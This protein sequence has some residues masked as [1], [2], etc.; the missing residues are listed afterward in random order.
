MHILIRA[1]AILV[2]IAALLAPSVL[3]A[4]GVPCGPSERV[5]AFLLHQGEQ[6][7]AT[8][9]AGHGARMALHV[10]E[11]GRW[12]LLL[13]LPDGRSCILANGADFTLL[14]PDPAA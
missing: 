10:A 2:L 3:A 4:Q 9:V 6:L 7:R 13:H 1:L 12:S 14:S 8:G 11:D 5:A